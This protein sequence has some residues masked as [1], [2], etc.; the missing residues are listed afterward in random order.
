M[1]G[2]YVNGASDTN[3]RSQDLDTGASGTDGGTPASTALPG[4]KRKQPG[5]SH[6]ANGRCQVRNRQGRER[7]RPCDVQGL[8]LDLVCSE[9]L[10]DEQDLRV[11]RER[12]GVV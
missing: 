7:R 9:A 1:V 11:L 12:P 2:L 8:R 10:L 6:A 4:A 5:E 3:G